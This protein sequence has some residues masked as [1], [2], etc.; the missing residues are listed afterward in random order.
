MPNGHEQQKLVQ[1]W[2]HICFKAVDLELT[3]VLGN[4]SLTI[5]LPREVMFQGADPIDAK[6][7]IED[8]FQGAYV[9]APSVVT[10]PQFG[11]LQFIGNGWVYTPSELSNVVDDS[12]TYV[13]EANYLTSNEATVTII[14]TSKPKE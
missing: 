14:G 5:E 12:F 4:V 10:E 13:V 3:Y 11:T 7:M 1:K 6:V 9:C 8:K 2:R